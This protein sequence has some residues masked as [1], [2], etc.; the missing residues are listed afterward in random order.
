MRH[1]LEIALGDVVTT[2]QYQHI[3]EA[4]DLLNQ[5]GLSGHDTELQNVLG[6]QDGISDTPTLIDRVYEVL[7]T[8]L[9]SVSLQYGVVLEEGTPLSIMT[10]IIRGLSLFEQYIQTEFFYQ[11][12][13]SED[14]DNEERLSELM[15]VLG[16]LDSETVLESIVS[17]KESAIERMLEVTKEALALEPEEEVNVESARTRT[18]L[19]NRLAPFSDSPLL[20]YQLAKSGYRM[21]RDWEALLDAWMVDL[22]ELIDSG[23]PLAVELMG[24]YLYSG[25]EVDLPQIRQTLITELQELPHYTEERAVREVD[26]LYRQLG[27]DHG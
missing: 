8:G 22:D 12:L 23:A 7:I 5:L 13:T 9:G 19:I 18:L 21:G 14:L 1:E 25:E 26:Q 17:V 6:L 27:I 15:P 11:V 16:D 4:Y 3:L 24:L 2:T 10:K 20:V